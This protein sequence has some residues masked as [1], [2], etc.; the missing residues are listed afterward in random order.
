MCLWGVPTL[1]LKHWGLSF[2]WRELYGGPAAGFMALGA[3]HFTG[4]YIPPAHWVGINGHFF[5]PN[6]AYRYPGL[7]TA[8]QFLLPFST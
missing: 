6:P 1:P 8:G 5:P 2:P 7:A 3:G 4:I